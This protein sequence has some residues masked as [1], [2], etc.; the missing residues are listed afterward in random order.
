MKDKTQYHFSFH[1]SKGYYEGIEYD[2]SR[3]AMA[4]I[5][6]EHRLEG[7]EIIKYKTKDGSNHL[8]VIDLGENFIRLEP[9]QGEKT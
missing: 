8:Y 2:L 4:L 6:R 9:T 3:E 5:L 7:D 1:T